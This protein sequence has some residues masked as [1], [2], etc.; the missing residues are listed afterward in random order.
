MKQRRK[1]EILFSCCLVVFF[2]VLSCKH[3]YAQ[4]LLKQG[5]SGANVIALQTKLRDCGYYFDAVDGSFGSHTRQ[6][7]INFQ[8]DYGLPADGIVGS[9]TLQALQNSSGKASRGYANRFANQ[10]VS[11]AKTFCGV[12]YMWAGKSPAGFDCSGFIYYVFSQ[13][14][15]SLPRMADEQFW[16][17]V[18]IN[19][20]ELQ[21]GD[22]VFFSTYEPGPSHVGLYLGE[23]D[24]I[25]ASSGAGVVTITSLDTPYYQA[26]YLGA[27]RILR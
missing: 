27:R 2:I 4:E 21:P 8:I 17:G 7:V 14:G 10:L 3:V 24:F 9:N 11:C 19:K 22:L 16:T 18:S 15:I 12:Q 5:M 13:N 20:R 6:A 23:G 1:F 25:H 26:R